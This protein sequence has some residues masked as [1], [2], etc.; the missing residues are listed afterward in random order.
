M[1]KYYEKLREL[2]EDLEPKPTQSEVGSN[3]GITQRKLSFIEKGFTEP[4]IQD[5]IALCKYYGV[6]ADYILGL[7]YDLKHPEQ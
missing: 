4:N 1:K 6:S 2:R 7:P 3:C 5:L